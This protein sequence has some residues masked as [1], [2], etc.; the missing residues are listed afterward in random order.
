MSC[1]TSRDRI[2]G[3]E[4]LIILAPC[5]LSTFTEQ[6]RVGLLTLSVGNIMVSLS[7]KLSASVIHR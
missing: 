6:K 2:S 4:S 7:L 3:S 5:L 1:I